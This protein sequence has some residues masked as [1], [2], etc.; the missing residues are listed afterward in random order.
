MACEHGADMR[1]KD[2]GIQGLLPAYQEQKLDRQEVLRVERHLDSCADC[3][4]ELSLIRMMAE[5]AVPDPGDLFWET[6]PD[7]VFRAVRREQGQKKRPGLAAFLDQFTFCRLAAAATTICILLLVSLLAFK[8]VQRAPNASQ[9]GGNEVADEALVVGDGV[10]LNELSR[11][12]LD[13]VGAWA[14]AQ[15]ASLSAEMGNSPANGAQET[16]LDEE[17]N[18]LNAREVERLSRMI[19][20]WVEEG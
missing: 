16:D 7:R 4:M 18:E 3:Q 10:P 14:G 19:D 20:Q 17:L 5:D 2:R 1:C 11:D 13:N 9:G 12:E 6:M 15:L 8:T